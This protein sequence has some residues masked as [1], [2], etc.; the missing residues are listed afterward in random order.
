VIKKRRIGLAALV[1]GLPLPSCSDASSPAGDELVDPTGNGGANTAMT[2]GGRGGS[3]AR[4]GAG[5]APLVTLPPRIAG[6]LRASS[7]RLVVEIDATE[8]LAPYPE[9]IAYLRSW[10]ASVVDKPDGIEL[11][12]DEALQPMGSSFEWTFATLDSFARQH[13]QA[14][15]D[16]AP[17]IH[18]LAL[19][20]R[21]VAEG[22]PGVILGLAWGNRFVAL[23]QDAIRERCRSGLT[24]ALQQ[25]VCKLAERNVWAHEL[26]HTL[27]LVD[28]G[29]PMQTEHRDPDHGKH[30]LREGC[31]MYW[32]YDGPQVFDTLLAR[33]G[34]Q[35]QDLDLCDESRQDIEAAR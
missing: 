3:A 1:L 26:G 32:A 14:D 11:E 28:N 15:D 19:D 30:D 7:P 21:Y 33:F 5:N 9:S 18:V 27:G 25:D 2:S 6:Y 12:A 23:F 34:S 29:I 22:D 4:G 13:A 10:L 24:G 16:A 17:R 20:G 8:A 31:L 35:D